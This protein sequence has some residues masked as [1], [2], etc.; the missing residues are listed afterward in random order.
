MKKVMET[1]LGMGPHKVAVRKER[2]SDFDHIHIYTCDRCGGLR[3]VHKV[4]G[5]Y[6]PEMGRRMGKTPDLDCVYLRCVLKAE[7]DDDG[8]PR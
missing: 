8:F 1:V 7:E 6:N 4:Y 3:C 5:S 2:A